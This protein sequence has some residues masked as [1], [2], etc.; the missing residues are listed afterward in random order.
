MYLW[1][2]ADHWC[3]HQLV[4]SEDS[5]LCCQSG[6]CL[7]CCRL[8]CAVHTI[9]SEHNSRVMLGHCNHTI[10]CY[11]YAVLSKVAKKCAVIGQS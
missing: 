7:E 10:Y 8:V 9:M 6:D 5:G 2:A 3:N 1:R 4:S 11:A